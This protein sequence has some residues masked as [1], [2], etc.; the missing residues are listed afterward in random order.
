MLKTSIIFTAYDSTQLL[1][2]ISCLALQSIMKYTDDKDYELIFMDTIP[3][4]CENHLRFDDAYNCIELNQ[5][6]DR[7]WI[8]RLEDEEGDPGQ[9]EMYNIGATYASGDLLCF[10]QNDVF[11]TEGWL[12]TLRYYIEKDMADVVFPDQGGRKRQ[13]MLDSYDLT[14]EEAIGGERNAGLIL[15]TREAFD[16]SGGWD[17]RIKLNYGEKRFYSDLEET[18]ARLLTTY[19][20]RIMHI[21]SATNWDKKTR[22]VDLFNKQ[23]D[24]STEALNAPR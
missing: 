12:P 22:D 23:T 16:K 13:E 9:Y 4:G 24:I 7:R 20:T 5:R 21:A 6:P 15:M 19:K 3:S 2:Q 11:V 14:P 8:Q 1:R 18:G 17:G 10:Y